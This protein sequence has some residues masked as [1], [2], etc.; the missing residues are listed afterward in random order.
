MKRVNVRRSM[1]LSNLVEAKA[2]LPRTT[3]TS[4][5]PWKNSPMLN[6]MTLRVSIRNEHLDDFPSFIE[7]SAIPT[8]ARLYAS[9]SENRPAASCSS[10]HAEVVPCTFRQKAAN[11]PAA[12]PMF[13]STGC[14][15]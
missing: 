14:K 7:A 1:V 15:R 11:A 6:V 4:C 10:R 13:H 2:D 3:L 5:V 12:S 8:P 9:G